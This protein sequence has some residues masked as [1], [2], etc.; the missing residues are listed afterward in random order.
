MNKAEAFVSRLCRRTFLSWWSYPNPKKNNSN[1]ELCDLLVVCDPDIIIFSVKKIEVTRSGDISI[2]WERWQKKAIEKSADQIYGAER[3][4]NQ[5]GVKYVTTKDDQEGLPIPPPSRRKTHR[6]AVAL[7]SKGKVPRYAG[8]LGKGFVHVFDEK[9]FET[10][11]QELNTIT[12][13]LKYLRSKEDFLSKAPNRIFASGEEDLL[14]LYLQN[15]RTF[16]EGA[17]LLFLDEGLWKKITK[18]PEYLRRKKEDQYSNVWDIII[19]SVASHLTE[20]SLKYRDPTKIEQALRIMARESRFARRALSKCFI[21]FLGRK[22]PSRFFTAQS[23]IVYVF[24][25]HQRSMR[26]NEI[27]RELKDRCLVARG[28]SPKQTTTLGIATPYYDK[29]PHSYIIHL[30]VKKK[31]TNRDQISMEKL[32]KEKE[33]F[34]DLRKSSWEENEYPSNSD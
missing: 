28:L 7:G 32:Q 10:I 13:F 3:H 11:L 9:S 2:D 25:A 8:D 30:F 14:A 34:V 5:S 33:Y 4:L 27:L 22:L 21:D 19:E 17:N 23:G 18:R 16:P 26:E 15:N 20:G 31:W 1:K 6:V 29:N 24:L 12:D